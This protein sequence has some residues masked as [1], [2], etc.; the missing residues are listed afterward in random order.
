MFEIGNEMDFVLSE[1]KR[2]RNRY[3]KVKI[4][5]LMYLIENNKLNL[6]KE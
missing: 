3:P 5:P 4:A 6:I 2:L 1:A